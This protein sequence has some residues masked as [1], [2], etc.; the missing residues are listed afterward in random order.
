MSK[1]GFLKRM[2][3]GVSAKSTPEEDRL[4]DCVVALRGVEKDLKKKIPL[5]E[6]KSALFQVHKTTAA[7]SFELLLWDKLRDKGWHAYPSR[8][9]DLEITGSLHTLC[10]QAAEGD[11]ARLN[12]DI[13][14]ANYKKGHSFGKEGTNENLKRSVKFLITHVG[15]LEEVVKELRAFRP[16]DLAP[17]HKCLL[18]SRDD[19]NRP[20]LYDQL[21]NDFGLY[22]KLRGIPSHLKVLPFA[23]V[24]APPKPAFGP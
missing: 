8:D 11:K 23:E 15:E 12:F 3:Y 20:P 9:R 21:K 1:Y 7:W 5:P 24:T 14:L 22:T 16:D 18:V 19:E 13:V 17:R 6:G 2:F 4:F 10:I